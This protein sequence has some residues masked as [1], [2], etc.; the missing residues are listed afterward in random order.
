MA[1]TT[2]IN[3]ATA[4][5]STE[6]GSGKALPIIVILASLLFV[7]LAVAGYFYYQYRQSPKVQS[8]EEIKNLK[9][10]IGAIF[11]LPTDEEPTLA[12]VTDREKLA[13]Q[14]F[15]QKAENGDKVLIYSNSGRAVLYR[16]SAKKI[17]DVTTVNV[18]KPEPEVPVETPSVAPSPEVSEQSSVPAII[19]VALYNG[20]I[21]VGVTNSIESVLRAAV[22]NAAVVTKETAV[23]NDYQKTLVIDVSGANGAAALSVASA[24]GGEVGGLPAGEKAPADADVLVIVGND[25]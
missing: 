24:V 11:E 4:T 19:R 12:T 5:V 22:P 6:T 17:I 8:A 7:A 10:E 3:P 13:E 14:P 18:T 16:P 23:K 21:E 1:R 20:S 9:E 2:K 15:F 25:R